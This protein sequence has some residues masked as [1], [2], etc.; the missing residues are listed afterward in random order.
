MEAGWDLITIK[1]SWWP[2]QDHTA[3]D[4]EG[5]KSTESKAFRTLTL[6]TGCTLVTPGELFKQ[7]QNLGLPRDQLNQVLSVE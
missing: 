1:M 7:S 4:G 5:K 6:H 2:D 3:M